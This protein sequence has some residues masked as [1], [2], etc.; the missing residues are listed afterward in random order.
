[1]G[2]SLVYIAEFSY[3]QKLPHSISGERSRTVTR[4][5]V[6]DV[7]CGCLPMWDRGHCFI[8]AEGAGSCMHVDQA[9]WSNV[10]KNFSG[11]KLVATWGPEDAKA[12]LAACGG[13]LFRKPLSP[14]QCSAL[15]TAS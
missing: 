11:Y 4:R 9:W 15:S 12:V 7:V 8:G 2:G 14:E 5:D 6:R 1:M 3:K 13:T 10:G